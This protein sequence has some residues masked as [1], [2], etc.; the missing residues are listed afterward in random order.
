MALTGIREGPGVELPALR[1]HPEAD[2]IEFRCADRADL[3]GQP[4]GPLQ[5]LTAGPLQLKHGAAIA[6]S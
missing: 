4:R 3:S 2:L 6:Q 1:L 5:A